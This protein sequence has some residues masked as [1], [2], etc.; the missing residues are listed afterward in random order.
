MPFEQL[1]PRDDDELRALFFGH[2]HDAAGS[3][4]AAPLEAGRPSRQVTTEELVAPLFKPVATVVGD[5]GWRPF[6]KD[7][8]HHDF[9]VPIGE[10]VHKAGHVGCGELGPVQGDEQTVE[11]AGAQPERLG[12]D[13]DHWFGGVGQDPEDGGARRATP[14]REAPGTEDAGDDVPCVELS[15]QCLDHRSRNPP[16]IEAGSRHGFLRGVGHVLADVYGVDGPVEQ[17]GEPAGQRR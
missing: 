13:D 3:I 4:A 14:N 17:L 12:R 10:R 16:H 9:A 11:R 2:L 6:P 8:E 15:Q 7:V 5:R 1:S